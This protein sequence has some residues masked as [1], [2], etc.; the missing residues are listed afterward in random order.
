MT[1]LDWE[2]I[3][4]GDQEAYSE[5]YVFY[6][7]KL[8]NYGRKFTDNE[9]LLED[10]IQEVLMDLW[11]RRE[12]LSSIEFPHTYILTAFRYTLLRRLK[13]HASMLGPA[14]IPE[15]AYEFGAEYLLIKKETE[16]RLKQRLEAALQQLTARQREAIF[17]RF[18]ENLSYD[19]VAGI[20]GIS[21]KATYKIVARALQQLKQG[22]GLPMATLLLLLRNINC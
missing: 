16:E 3:K 8:Y 15:T 11:R 20:L 1:K 4:T 17:L 19:E 18:Y 2:H 10:V 21:T 22:M 12:R 5:A 13:Q 6:Y 9:A 7:R 14:S